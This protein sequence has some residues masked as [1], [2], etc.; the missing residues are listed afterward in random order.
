M[1]RRLFSPPDEHP[2]ADRIELQSQIPARH[3]LRALGATVPDVEVDLA[4]IRAPGLIGF[5]GEMG[6]LQ[7][8]ISRGVVLPPLITALERYRDSGDRTTY[9]VGFYPI[10]RG[11]L[12]IGEWRALDADV[13]V[14][15]RGGRD[16][17]LVAS[18]VPVTTLIA[19]LANLSQRRPI[20][21]GIEMRN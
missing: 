14:E 4:S 5:F 16:C 3:V 1:R 6:S 13:R 8:I 20:A 12:A 10:D 2:L 7:L 17:K 11:H 19:A 15:P 9:L 18:S 21:T